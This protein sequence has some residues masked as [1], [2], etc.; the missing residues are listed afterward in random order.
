MKPL[1]LRAL[2]FIEAANFTP[3]QRTSIDLIVLHSTE[4]LEKAGSA[5]NVATWFA[6]PTAPQASAHYVIDPVDVI[7]CVPDES[8]AWHAPGANAKGIGIELCGH[9]A[10]TAI[11]WGDEDSMAI[12]GHAIDLCELLCRKWD[13]PPVL[14]DVKDIALR[15]ARGF[16]THAMV[17]RAFPDLGSGHWD[18]GPEFPLE[19]FV[20]RVAARFA[21]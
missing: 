8:V 6:G 19:W 12:L 3:A 21:P 7:R 9:A 13:I 5:R 16:C 4:G 11:E 20:G 10:Q 1:D 2:P 17:S 15:M 18:P 14:V